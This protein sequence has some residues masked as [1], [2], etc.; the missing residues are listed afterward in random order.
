MEVSEAHA[1]V[2]GHLIVTSF[3]HIIALCGIIG[4]DIDLDAKLGELLRN[5]LRRSEIFCEIGGELLIKLH[6]F[7]P[8]IVPASSRAPFFGFSLRH[9]TCS[10]HTTL[11]SISIRYLLLSE[12]SSGRCI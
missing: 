1:N 7:S 2:H 10:R 5:V 11:S 4:L 6:L 9:T 12:S 3:M 8:V